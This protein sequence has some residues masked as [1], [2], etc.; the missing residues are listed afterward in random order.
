LEIFLNNQFFAD[1]GHFSDILFAIPLPPTK[2]EKVIAI[3]KKIRRFSILVDSKLALKDLNLQLS[4]FNLKI[5]VFITV[6]AGYDREGLEPSGI[7]TDSYIYRGI[8]N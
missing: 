3:A 2:F 4:T 1:S 6:C 7:D 5:G 8:D